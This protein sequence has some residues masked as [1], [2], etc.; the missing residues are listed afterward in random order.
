M[1]RKRCVIF[2]TTSQWI[3]QTL[4]IT[5]IAKGHIFKL[6]D[7]F[8]YKYFYHLI[9]CVS[10]VLIVISVFAQNAMHSRD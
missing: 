9:M 6:T 3:L 4:S 7:Y 5:T 10:L 2:Q 8:I 1:A